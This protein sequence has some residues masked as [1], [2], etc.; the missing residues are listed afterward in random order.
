MAPVLMINISQTIVKNTIMFHPPVFAFVSVVVI[1]IAFSKERFSV[2]GRLRL[3]SL[4]TV[5]SNTVCEHIYVVF[6][7]NTYRYLI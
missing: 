2:L 4:N 3:F 5:C 7:I 6:L 1:C